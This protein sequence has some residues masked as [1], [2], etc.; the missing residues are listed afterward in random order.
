MPKIRTETSINNL[1][2]FLGG[3]FMCQNQKPEKYDTSGSATPPT[4]AAPAQSKVFEI[5]RWSNHCYISM[6]AISQYIYFE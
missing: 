2:N 5:P 4:L 3:L 6:I 1:A